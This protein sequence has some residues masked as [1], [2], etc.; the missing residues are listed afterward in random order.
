MNLVFMLYAQQYLLNRVMAPD[1]II[2]P[3]A[4][5]E[6]LKEKAINTVDDF[7][8]V[9]KTHSDGIKGVSFTEDK[10]LF[11]FSF[12]GRSEKVRGIIEMLGLAFQSAKKSKC[13]SLRKR[14]LKTRN[15]ICVC[16][17]FGLAWGRK[18]TTNPAWNS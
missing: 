5:V 13:I 6:A 2:I 18:D 7:L 15:T 3:E 4:F 17:S 1:A 9:C 16:G 12:K 14:S 11:R 10:V 8:D